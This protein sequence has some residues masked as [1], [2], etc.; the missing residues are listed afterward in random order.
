MASLF[1]DLFRGRSWDSWRV[2]ARA[3]DGARLTGSELELWKEHTGRSIGPS[4][5]A[6]ELWLACGRR[7]GK[8]RF[9]A[10][11][12]VHAAVLRQHRLGPGERGLAMLIAADRKQARVLKQYVRALL[13]V[14]AL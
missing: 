9:A 2:V 11:L 14:P 12:A 4:A 13:A 7:S 5:P 6:R 8:S 3:M 10:L 1:A